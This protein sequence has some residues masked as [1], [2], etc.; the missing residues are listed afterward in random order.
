MEPNAETGSPMSDW[1]TLSKA[2]EDIRDSWVLIS[3]CLTD[4]MAEAPSP[5]RD[6]TAVTT[7]RYLHGFR[8]TNQDKDAHT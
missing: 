7:E 4:F 1:R 6:E 5:L 3:F 8:I 2:L